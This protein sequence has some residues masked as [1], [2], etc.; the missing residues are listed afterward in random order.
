LAVVVAGLAIALLPLIPAVVLVLG[1]LALL[2]TFIRPIYGLV[3][4]AFSV[5]FGSLAEIKLADFSLSATEFVVP[6][7]VLAWVFQMVAARE[8]RIRFTPIFGTLL[9]LIAAMALSVS[10]ARSLGLSLKE[11]AKWLE[12][13]AI[14]LMVGNSVRQRRQIGVIL[15]AL[16]AAGVL[17][18]LHGWY[19]F[20]LKQGPEG[21]LVGGTFLRAYGVFGQPN[22]YGGYLASLIP[23]SLGLFLAAR[24]ASSRWGNPWVLAAVGGILTLG[25][26]MSLSRG[27]MLGLAGAVLLM[28]VIGSRRWRPAVLAGLLALSL[29]VLA[30]PFGL[31]PG[32]L[33]GVVGG[34]LGGFSIFDVR[35]VVP[36]PANFSIIQRLA[37]WSSAWSMWLEHPW[38]GIG[39]GNFGV[40][41][42]RYALPF[43]D[44]PQEHAHNYYLNLLAETGVVGLAAYLIFFASLLAF[45][46]QGL[47]A[48]LAGEAGWGPRAFLAL[49]IVGML[50]V[51]S[52]HNLF[53]NIY[54]HGLLV[55]LGMV[56]GLVPALAR[57][58][59]GNYPEEEGGSPND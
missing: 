24:A 27:G 28:L 42:P 36:T 45:A 57:E 56:L 54:V 39:V 29:G 33:Q 25:L 52:L 6:L 51:F 10:E 44:F 20:V 17:E 19:Q 14:F 2:L 48:A 13:G 34:F 40:L 47:R 41:Y 4:L 59:V 21:F 12:F 3:L 55:Q 58:R 43:W 11:I 18:A 1:G 49:G 22:P 23:L 38:L 30:F 8:V 35:G 26:L 37:V 46:G 15:A 5:P 53:D 9:L 31:L 50:L 7:V 16:L 32:P